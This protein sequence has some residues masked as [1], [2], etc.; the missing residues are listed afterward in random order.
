MKKFFYLFA[1]LFAASFAF[2]QNNYAHQNGGSDFQPVRGVQV[3]V[4]ADSVQYWIGSGANQIVTAIFYCNNENPVGIV[5][6][7]RWDG[8]KTIK[9]MFDDIAAED[10][11]HFS[12]S[13][14]STN[15]LFDVISYHNTDLGLNLTFP[16]GYCMYTM[17]GD[18]SSGITDPLVNNAYFELQEWS[19][20]CEDYDDATLY[21]LAAP[22]DPYVP[23]LVPANINF[24]VGS[25]SQETY[26]TF[27]W[28]QND[29]PVGIA[30]GY[31]W[32]GNQDI[33]TMLNAIDAA[34]NRLTITYNDWG[35]NNYT[36]VD[37]EHNYTLAN[38][39]WLSYTI[40]GEY[41]MGLT[42][43]I[44]D[45]SYFDMTEYASCTFTDFSILYVSTPV[46]IANHSMDASLKAYPNPTTG[47]VRVTSDNNIQQVEV[48]DLFGKLL[49]KVDGNDSHEVNVSLEGLVNGQYILKANNQTLKVVKQD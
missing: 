27:A 31:R 8:T 12:V 19:M 6:G 47:N 30:Y 2:A 25:G 49:Q 16:S 46:G 22:A 9:D 3:N 14:N 4:S 37:N 7:Y 33:Q 23:V 24:W 15:T 11:A 17:N 21:Y 20:D 32:D 35:V 43:P 40:D 44:V 45:R 38:E 10:S 29:V 1:I 13:Y 28:C 48:Y 26:V 5:Y 42:D 39:G 18:Y 41:C 36:F 34:D